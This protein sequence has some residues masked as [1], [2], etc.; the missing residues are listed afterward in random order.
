LEI[1]YFIELA[2]R[3]TQARSSCCLEA[4]TQDVDAL[5]IILTL[6]H[7]E[8][9]LVL[10]D[11]TQDSTSKK[12]HVLTT[13]RILNAALE[14]GQLLLVTLQYPLKIESLDFLIEPDRKA[15]IHGRNTRKHNV[16]L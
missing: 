13:R 3:D 8:G 7:P 6:V 10:H 2:R 9:G 5:L 1:V 12:D 4:L 14:L 15:R 11:F 16:F